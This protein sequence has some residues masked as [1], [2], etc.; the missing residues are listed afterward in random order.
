MK[1]AFT[2]VVLIVTPTMAF[3]QGTVGFYNSLTGLVK[4]WTSATDPTL[5]SVPT[6]GGYVQLIAAPTGTPLPNSLFTATMGGNYAKYDSLSS[7]L[8]A[9]PGWAATVN[10]SGAVPAPIRGVAGAF[11][12]GTY[13]INNIVA[14]PQAGFAD[15]LVIGWTGGFSSYDAAYAAITVDQSASFL[16]M[17]AIA[18]TLTGDPLW[19]PPGAPIGLRTTFQGMTLAPLFPN[20]TPFYWSVWVL[21][22]SC[23]AQDGPGSPAAGPTGEPVEPGGH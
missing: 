11:N 5:I 22:C 16:G 6:N 23:R 4:Q 8:L 20:R 18:T 12:G 14:D 3:A 9:N 21:S 10:N 2:L 17:S 19:T 1:K 7:F 13:T 15:Y